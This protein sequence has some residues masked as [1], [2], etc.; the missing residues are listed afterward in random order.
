MGKEVTA[1]VITGICTLIIGFFGASQYYQEQ[2]VIVN[3]A[4]EQMTV[5]TEKYQA[6]EEQIIALQNELKSYKDGSVS[7]PTQPSAT[8]K[9]NHY[10]IYALEPYSKSY[11]EKVTDGSMKMAG[12]T[13]N[14]GISLGT[15]YING[16]VLYNLEGKYTS[17]SGIIGYLD[18]G[19]SNN[20]NVEF[21]GDDILL[22]TIPVIEKD[23]PK[24]FSVD[25]SGVRKFMIKTERGSTDPIGLAEV[26]IK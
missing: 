17:L 1:A 8:S 14:N 5:T 13:Y 26:V 18:T 16:E 24:D 25:I 21:W 12:K 19:G 2:N 20:Q 6:L 9:K 10:L 22:E 23:L 3:I 11:C 15:S 4:G 7:K